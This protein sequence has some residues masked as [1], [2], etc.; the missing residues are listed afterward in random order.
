MGRRNDHTREEIKEMAIKA[1]LELIEEGGFLNCSARKVA[2][3]IGY[4]A[5]TL[6]NVFED[7]DDLVFHVNAVTLDDLKN[8]VVG[9]LDPELQGV[10][11]IKRLGVCYIEFAHENDFRWKALFDYRRPPGSE[12]PQ[13]YLLKLNSLFA[14][15]EKLLLPLVHGDIESAQRVAQVLWA[16]VHGICSLGLTQRLGQDGTELLKTMSDSLI[17][18]YLRGLTQTK[19]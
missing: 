13:W 1:G 4:S 10:E 3:R 16:G 9:N 12:L 17:E 6:Y 2:A 11:A 8:Y 15:G 5:G 14:I 18:N 19:K 7:Y